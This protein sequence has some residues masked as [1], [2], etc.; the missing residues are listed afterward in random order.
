MALVKEHGEE[1]A[2]AMS[3]DFGS[4]SAH[5]SMLTDIA[6]T[7][8]RGAHALK[9]MDGWAKTE[10]RKVQFRSACSGPRPNCATSPRA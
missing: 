8:A 3:A 1:F 9:H 2:K 4:R 6:A 7:V 10:K 5:Q